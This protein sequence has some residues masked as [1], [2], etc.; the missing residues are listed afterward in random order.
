MKEVNAIKRF[1]KTPTR[2]KAIFAM[3]F[4][5]MGGTRDEQPDPG[6]RDAIRDCKCDCPLHMYRPYRN[7]GVK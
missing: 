4:S 1:E 5:C 3:C 6:W 2:G 7:R